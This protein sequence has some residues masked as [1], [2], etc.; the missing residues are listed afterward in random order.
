MG[1]AGYDWRFAVRGL[2]RTCPAPSGFGS[3]LSE[4]CPSVPSDFNPRLYNVFERSLGGL[5]KLA[6]QDSNR[7]LGRFVCM[8]SAAQD[9]AQSLRNSRCSPE[10]ISAGSDVSPKKRPN[11][12]G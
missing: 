3:C 8:L 11:P 4:H 9:A 5:L 10:L 6:S 12:L 1:I 7:S 2:Q